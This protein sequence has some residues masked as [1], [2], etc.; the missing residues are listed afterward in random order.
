MMTGRHVG[1]RLSVLAHPFHRPGAVTTAMPVALH[2]VGRRDRPVQIPD[3][4]RVVR[5]V[6]GPLPIAHYGDHAADRS[7]AH[8][9]RRH[10][11]WV[12]VFHHDPVLAIL[13]DLLPELENEL[14]A[15]NP[16]HPALLVV[17]RLGPP[18]DLAAR[19]VLEAK[20]G[21]VVMDV[22]ADPED[23]GIHA[24]TGG[25][26]HLAVPRRY[27]EVLHAV[28]AH[29]IQVERIDRHGL[30]QS[31]VRPAVQE[32][33]VQVDVAEVLAQR[34]AEH[35]RDQHPAS[36][37]ERKADDARDALP[38]VFPSSGKNTAGDRRE[39]LAVVRI[40]QVHVVKQIG[41]QNLAVAVPDLP[42]E[43]VHEGVERELGP[44]HR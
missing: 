10:V 23:P 4:G 27:L 42:L 31:L 34:V 2:P 44:L 6:G 26:G 37:V 5:V 39:E 17:N 43:A 35:G 1:W 32:L 33:E 3:I 20:L 8:V 38:L 9:G 19:G 21:G 11:Q 28:E 12:L 14:R 22:A 7:H 15:R 25:V 24:G 16:D 40:D 30:D 41:R 18:E 36:L 13:V 29:H